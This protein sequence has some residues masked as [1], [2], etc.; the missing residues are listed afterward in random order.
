[1]K[2]W[3]LKVSGV[4]DT[5]PPVITDFNLQPSAVR[6]DQG[7]WG[8]RRWTAWPSQLSTPLV[9]LQQHC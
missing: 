4:P 2:I 9:C 8:S 7:Q 1:M 5:K 3:H 6:R